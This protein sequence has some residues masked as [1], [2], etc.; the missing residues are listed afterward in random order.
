MC[1]DDGDSKEHITSEH[2]GEIKQ[3][4][5]HLAANHLQQLYELYLYVC[6]YLFIFLV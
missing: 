3:M 5:K 6:I 2:I 1:G 4:E